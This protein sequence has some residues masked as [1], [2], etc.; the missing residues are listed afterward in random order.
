MIRRT[1]PPPYN[2][3]D[4]GR[5]YV[6]PERRAINITMPEQPKT[7]MPF[8]V[9]LAAFIF[10]VAASS[11]GTYISLHDEQLRLGFAIRQLETDTKEAN[12]IHN[13]THDKIFSQIE[14]LSSQL[15]STESTMT[16]IM[17]KTY[18]K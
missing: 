14:Q 4:D 3:E 8:W 6:G 9:Q 7:P 15:Q 10:T 17:N 1:N 5:M 2:D 12:D 18:R 16:S 11:I 13:K